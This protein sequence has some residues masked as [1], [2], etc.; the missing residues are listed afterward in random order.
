M[1]Y[2]LSCSLRKMVAISLASKLP[3]TAKGERQN[4]SGAVVVSRLSFF[5]GALMPDTE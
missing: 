2:E 3:G 1:P 4:G 5:K